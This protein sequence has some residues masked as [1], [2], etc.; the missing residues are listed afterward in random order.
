MA[1]GGQQK[2]PRV[3]GSSAQIVY[4]PHA[5]A[6]QDRGG[7]VIDAS[8]VCIDG[9]FK[10]RVKTLI[11]RV[12]NV[13]RDVK[14]G[15]DAVRWWLGYALLSKFRDGFSIVDCGFDSSAPIAKAGK[16][17][18]RDSVAEIADDKI[19]ITRTGELQCRSMMQIASCRDVGRHSFLD[20]F[21]TGDPR[22]YILE[23]GDLSTCCSRC[24]FTGPAVLAAVLQDSN[25]CTAAA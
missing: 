15:G 9:M 14:T 23:A 1:D 21:T 13:G 10:L 17:R 2:M 22:R 20:D 8:C 25:F 19:T 4:A 5:V 12:D 16:E 6:T 11:P 7:N 18:W 3:K 24:C